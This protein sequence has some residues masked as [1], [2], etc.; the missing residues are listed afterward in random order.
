M[1][2]IQKTARTTAVLILIMVVIAPFG[3]LYLPSILLV[4]GDASATAARILTSAW[5]LRL[6][7]VGDALVFLIEIVLCALLYTL[8]RPVHQPLALVAAFGRLVMTVVQGI[9]LLTYFVVLLL[10]SG[11]GYLAVFDPAQ[12]H[13]LVLLALQA[14]EAMVLIW[15]LAF[16]LHLLVLGYLVYTSRYLPR[17]VGALLIIAAFCYFIQSFGMMLF[18]Q[19]EK[20]FVS[21]GLLSI[22]EIALPFWL[23]I[24]GVEVEQWQQRTR[25]A[26]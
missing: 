1:S 22:V 2:S 20:I 14:H 15:G 16:G 24:K 21:I 3:M 11:A 18:P 19:Y 12:V 5:L 25:A 17:M 6:G 23:L 26:A 10:L 13:A 8:L 9:N 7:L 4:P